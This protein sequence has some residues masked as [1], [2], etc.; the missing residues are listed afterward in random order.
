MA[1]LTFT[2]TSSASASSSYFPL[3]QRKLPIIHCLD[4][5]KEAIQ[6]SSTNGHA[7][8]ATTFPEKGLLTRPAT[9]IPTPPRPRRIILVRHGQSEGNVDESVY[10]RVAD[11]KISLTAKGKAEAEECG[12]RIREMI[13]EDGADDWKVYFYVS[14][15]KRTLETLQHLGRAFERSRIAGMRE[16][17][18]IREQDFGRFT[19]L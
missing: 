3:P 4:T 2:P 16:E 11:P 10:A 19:T 1:T 8:N 9:S 13:E 14:P 7:L 17:P 12:W 18:R 6:I 15:Y 5:P